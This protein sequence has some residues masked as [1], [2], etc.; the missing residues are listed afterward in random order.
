ML[1]KKELTKNAGF[2]QSVICLLVEKSYENEIIDTNSEYEIGPGEQWDTKEEWMND[3]I[4]E[5]FNETAEKI[6]IFPNGDADFDVKKM[7]VD[8]ARSIYK[9]P[10]GESI[11]ISEEY[12]I[13]RVPGGWIYVIETMGSSESPVFVPYDEEFENLSKLK[14]DNLLSHPTE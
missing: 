2:L 13:I 7:A 6:K 4:T 10:L 12:R 11:T 8:M 5:W 3:K 9:L 14:L 1:E